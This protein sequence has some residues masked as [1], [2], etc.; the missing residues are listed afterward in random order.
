[1][2]ACECC[3]LRRWI[4]MEHRPTW[5]A[6]N[7]WDH[8]QIPL[9][10]P[11][12]LWNPKVQ[13]RVRKRPPL[14][15]TSYFSK[16]HFNIILLFAPRSCKW[17]FS[18][19]VSDEHHFTSLPFV[20]HVLNIS[21]FIIWLSDIWRR[22]QLW[23]PPPVMRITAVIFWV[24]VTKKPAKFASR[25]PITVIACGMVSPRVLECTGSLC[26]R[27]HKLKCWAVTAG[28]CSCHDTHNSF[29]GFCCI[30]HAIPT[31]NC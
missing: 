8:Q 26:T 20:L 4:H 9:S 6:G 28:R 2:H 3:I 16:R 24:L 22:E 31:K 10:P 12:H 14:A 15:L 5:E 13:Y 7:H 19:R 18:F 29:S 17:Y 1:M 21:Y 25:S 30:F 11:P 27:C 23:P